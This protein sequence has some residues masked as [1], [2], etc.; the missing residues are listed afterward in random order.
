MRVVLRESNVNGARVKGL[1][2]R[3][4]PAGTEVFDA[5][6]D[7]MESEYGALDCDYVFVNLFRPPVGAPMPRSA[8][9]DLAA[10][11]RKWTG[12]GHF[13][14]HV[15]QHSWAPRLLRAKGS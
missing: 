2:P 4:V 12:I 9:E 7:Y 14:P 11:L 13:T 6:A 8:I 10:Q 3:T 1:K 5:Y 15:L